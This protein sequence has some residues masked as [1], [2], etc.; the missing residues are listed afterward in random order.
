MTNQDYE[1]A[2]RRAWVEGRF[3]QYGLSDEEVMAFLPLP[4]D[5]FSQ[6]FMAGMEAAKKQPLAERLTEEEKEKVKFIHKEALTLSDGINLASLPDKAFPLVYFDR[7]NQLEHIFGKE[8]FNESKE[9][10]NG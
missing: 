1:K 8:F 9:E 10:D 5:N 6:G 7:R 3:Q 4:S 2:E